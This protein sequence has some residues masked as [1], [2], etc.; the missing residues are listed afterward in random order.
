VPLVGHEV[1]VEQVLAVLL[2][3]QGV[4]EL[5]AGLARH[6]PAQELDVRTGHLHVHH[7]VRAG[8]AEDDEQFVLAEQRRVDDE[9]AGLVVQDR[10]THRQLVEAVDDLAHQVSAL[11]AEEQRTQHLDLE[12]RPK[13]PLGQ[14][15]FQIRLHGGQHGVD[16]AGQ[17]FESGLELEVVN[18]ADQRLAQA[19]ARGVVGAVGGFG[20]GFVVLDVLG[21][22]GRPHEEELIAKVA[23][24]QQLGSHRVEEGLGQLGLVVVGQQADVV[25][26]GLLPGVLR[27]GIGTEL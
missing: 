17:V 22:D 7:E 2:Q 9:L 26:L 8:E 27:Q 13:P 10:Q 5:G 18:D 11:V 12:V 14:R 15:Q 19:L 4:V 24:V 16:V 1:A 20:C 3:P 23:A 21:A 6:Q 25:Q